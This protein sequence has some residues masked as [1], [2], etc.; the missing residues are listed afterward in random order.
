MNGKIHCQF[1]WDNEKKTISIVNKP[2]LL[3][4]LSERRTGFL[5]AELEDEF[6]GKSAEARAYFFSEVAV[7]AAMMYRS[8][9]Y[10][11]KDKYMAYNLLCLDEDIDCTDKILN[12]DGDVAARVPKRF[13]TLGQ[14]EL[15][16]FTNEC[17]MLIESLGF[18]VEDAETWK[19]RRKNP[20]SV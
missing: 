15:A 7:V 10:S 4:Q 5:D 13:S 17:I 8:L 3:E 6:T 1:H 16:Y 11:V 18:K 14:K 19:A 20:D 12:K 9:G 2:L